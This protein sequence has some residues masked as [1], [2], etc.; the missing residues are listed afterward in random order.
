MC[1]DSLLLQ[2]YQIFQKKNVFLGL[3]TLKNAGNNKK[4]QKK[5][6][7]IWKFEKH[8]ISLHPQMRNHLLLWWL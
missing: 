5:Q 1:K 3:Y 8:I 7:K 2:Y 4:N 6:Q